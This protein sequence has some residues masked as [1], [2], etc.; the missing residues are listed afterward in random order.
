MSLRKKLFGDKAFYKMVLTIVLP[1]IVQN[2]ITN[3]V[4]LLDNM[5]VGQVGTEQM[6]GVAIINQLMLV[7][8]LAV[9]GA[10]SG[11]GIF[12]A[13]FFGCK[14]Q[15]GVRQVLRFKLYVSAAII[16]IGAAILL[17]FGED[18]IMLYLHGEDTQGSLEATLQYGKQYLTVMLFGLFPFA[19]GEAYSSSL[20]ECGETKIPMIAGVTAVFVNLVLNYVLIFGKFGLPA[21]GVVGAA[22]ATVL[23]R[24]IQMAFVIVWTHTHKQKMPF[25]EGLFH[26]WRIPKQLLFNIVRKGMPLLINEIMWSAG[27]AMLNQCYSIRGLDAVAAQNISSTVSNLFNVVFLS[28]GNAISIIVGQLLGAGKMEE[29]KDADTKLIT[30]SVLGCLGMGSIMFLFAPFA[31]MIYNTTDA[32]RALATNLIRAASCCMPM[33]A[34][35]H[36]V[37]FTLRTGGKTIV[38]FFFDGV[39]LWGITVPVAYVLSRYTALSMVWLYVSCQLL[40]LIKCTVGFILV[41]KGDW[42]QNI[43]GEKAA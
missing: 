40:D 42:A 21:L 18:L 5:M 7:F 13:Q 27:I 35:V 38:T 33:W 30:F 31:P 37:Y 20:R 23:S 29:A 25:V 39:F 15:K 10:V 19:I 12:G 26:N 2:G 43:I 17:L 14:N 16:V 22:V 32:V 34:F 11:A 8:N 6:S 24:Y 28:L 3:F 4:N 1:I 41:K 36:A 9:F